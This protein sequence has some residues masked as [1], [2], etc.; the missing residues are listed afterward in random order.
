MRA[1][2]I[3]AA[4]ALVTSACASIAAMLQTREAAVSS[5]RDADDLG[6]VGSASERSTCPDSNA[7]RAFR[8]LLLFVAQRLL[9]AQLHADRAADGFFLRKA[10]EAALALIGLSKTRTC[11]APLHW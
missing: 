1:E 10:D 8:Y 5:I 9:V 3:I 6:G 4:L 2:L 11:M 7:A